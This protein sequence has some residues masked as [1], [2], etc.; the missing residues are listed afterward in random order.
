MTTNQT[1]DG[2]P[3]DLSVSITLTKQQERDILRFYD[4]C[5]DG[6]GYDVP[7]DR[8]KSLACLG[9]IR[10]T[11]FSR[12][13]ITDAGDAAIE[14]LRALLDTPAIKPRPFGYWLTP[15]TCAGLAM[16]QREL[17]EDPV[18]TASVVEYFHV[19]PLYDKPPAQPQGSV[20]ENIIDLDAVC[21]FE[22]L[23]A[24]SES[25]WMPLEYTRNDWVDDVCRF[26]REGPDSFVDSQPQSA[27]VAVDAA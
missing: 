21:W 8:M 14:K 6:Q 26:L 4:T 24:A 12:Y 15:K 7:K 23:R 27:P 1:I 18:L 20:A 25:S 19:K 2:V 9:L 16:F 22:I 5:E 13:E 10:P 3:R 11:G 17:I